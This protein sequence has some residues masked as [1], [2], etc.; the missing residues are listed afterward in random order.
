MRHESSVSRRL[1]AWLRGLALAGV[2]ALGLLTLVGSGGGSLGFPPCPPDLCGPAPP[3]TAGVI[4]TPGRLTVLVGTPVTFTAQP[5]N[6]TAAVTYQWRRSSGVG[7][8]LVDIPGATGSTYTLPGA[9]LDDDGVLFRVMMTPSDGG[10]PVYDSG[11]LAV[12]AVPGVVFADGEFATSGWETLPV[13]VAGAV[14]PDHLEE[15]V[16]SGGNPGAYRSMVFR[17]GQGT[18]S[19]AVAYL[20]RSAAY[21]PSVQGPVYVID[22]AEDC[23]ALNPSELLSTISQLLVQQ[24][25]RTY[26]SSVDTLHCVV[27]AWEPVANRASLSVGEFA[28]LDGPACAAGESCPDFSANAL[29]LRFGYR[30]VSFASSGV[31]VAHGIDNWRVT[32]WPR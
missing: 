8:P 30:R 27:S 24:G 4:V 10:L 18:G 32:V 11:R 23:S 19:G 6:T 26:V 31:E 16:P 12:S 22:Y 13:D 21:D 25:A 28:L 29:P 17:L 1:G 5:V 15:Q 20:L 2:S 9:N 3:P 14:R 7:T